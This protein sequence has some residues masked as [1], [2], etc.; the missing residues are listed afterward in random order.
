MKN[1]QENDLLVDRAFLNN[2]SLWP[3]DWLDR[4][5][6]RLKTRALMPLRRCGYI[7]HDEPLTIW[8]DFA[9]GDILEVAVPEIFPSLNELLKVWMVD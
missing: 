9:G 3:T 5:C 8:V 1:R 7:F 2:P 6:C 4:K